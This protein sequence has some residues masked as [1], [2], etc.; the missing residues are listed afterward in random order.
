[1]DWNA[2]GRALKKLHQHRPTIIK[3]IHQILPLGDR[4]HKYD[5]KYPP[6][7]PSCGA[8]NENLVHFWNCQASTR[9]NW[10]RQFLRELN[11]KLI[12]LRTGPEVRNL[13]VAKLRAV[14]D[15]VPTNTIPVEPQLAEIANQQDQIGWEQIMRGRFGWAWNDHP[16]TQ[17]GQ[18]EQHAGHW[19][20]EVISFILEQWRKLWDTRNQDRHGRD[21][22]SQLQAQALQVDREL[23]LFYEEY[24][25]QAPQ[26]LKWL[27]D[28]SIETHRKRPV[29]ATRQWL[30]TWAP[31]MAATVTVR[32]D[33]E[34][35]PTNPENYP[36]TTALE[37]G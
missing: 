34:G 23:Q 4:T 30:N 13:L 5:R 32:E 8:P 28:T 24:A 18:S 17:P 33:P 37:T 6:H 31:I 12:D 3:Y 14:L 22:A 26:E 15:G 1:M 25:E 9:I 11:Q 35:D 7:C 10:R 16:R 27:F 29:A 19:T 2:H 20:T 36:Y 21:I